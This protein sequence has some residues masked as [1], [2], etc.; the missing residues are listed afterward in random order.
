[1][2]S[3]HELPEL[4]RLDH[5]RIHPEIVVFSKSIRSRDEVNMTMGMCFSASSAFTAANIS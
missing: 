1:M 3:V 2:N 5:V 4:D